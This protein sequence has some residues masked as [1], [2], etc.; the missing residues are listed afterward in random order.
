[1]LRDARARFRPAQA[2]ILQLDLTLAGTKYETMKSALDIL[3]IAPEFDLVLAVV[4]SSA[5]F[6]PQLAVRPIVECAGHA[7]PLAAM[8]VPDAPEALASLTAAGVP[9]FRSPEGCADAIA[10]VLAR[11]RPGQ[12]PTTLARETAASTLSEDKS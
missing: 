8:L 1:M 6:Q 2:D 4:G 5:R 11:R 7:K 10:A 12:E 9:C 3:L